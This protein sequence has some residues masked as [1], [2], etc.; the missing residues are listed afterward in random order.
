MIT[1]FRHISV[2]GLL[3]L[4]FIALA[5]A[6]KVSRLGP[7]PLDLPWSQGTSRS[8]STDETFYDSQN[9]TQVADKKSSPTKSSSLNVTAVAYLVGDVRTG[10]VLFGR[11]TAKALPVASMSKL[12]TAIESI[13]RLSATDP[14]EVTEAEIA[15]ASDSIRWMPGERFAMNELLYPMLLNSSNVAAEALASSTDRRKFMENMSSYAWE[16]GMPATYFADPTGLSPQ[17]ISTAADFFALARYLYSRRPDILEITRT[18]TFEVATTS[19]HGAHIFTSIHPFVDDPNFIGGKTGHTEIA[20]DTLLTIMKVGSRSLAFI[21]LGSENRK[22]D[23]E[24]LIGLA[25]KSLG[26]K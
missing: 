9:Q 26:V 10:Q 14:I 16:I 13:D 18:S 2:V 3:S 22:A 19:D 15:V 4:A 21:V 6:I 20:R 8:L 17:N 23:T 11:N 1:S 5:V 25:K 12:I 24:V 7:S